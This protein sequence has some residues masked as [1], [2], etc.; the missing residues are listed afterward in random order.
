M[1]DYKIKIGLAPI[2]RDVTPRPGIFNWEKAE[3]RAEKYVKYITEHFTED[4]VEF[5]NVDGVNE[6]NIIYTEADAEVIADR[7]ISEKVDA[8]FVINCN[9]GNE[10]AAA[11]LCKRVGKPALLWAPLDDVFEADGM[12]YTDSQCGLFG[13]SKQFVRRKI[14]FS[15]IPNCRV[16]EKAF[17]DGLN[18]FISVAC[19]VK[20]FK[21][22]R[23]GQVGLRPKPFCSVIYNE[24]ELMENFDIRVIPINMA[25]IA[26][27]YNRILAERMD[28]CKKGS[29]IL[30]KNYE[31]D[32]LSADKLEKIY[33][34]VLMYIDLFKEHDLDVIASECWTSMQLAFG[35]MPCAALSILADMGY[36]VGCETDVHASITQALLKCASRGKG[37]PFLGEFTVRHPE[38]I[39]TELLWHCG[40]FAYSL[41]KPESPSKLVNMR[42]WFNVKNGSYTAARLDQE[43][44]K[45]SIIVGNC[46]SADGPYTFGTYLWA[47]FENLPLWEKR[48][49]EGPYIHHISEIE[50]DYVAE[51]EEFCKFIGDITPEIIK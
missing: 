2:R 16:E 46:N 23:V 15:Y 28:E 38:D 24:S 33:A 25:V 49:I 19:M 47:K 29:E 11:E 42:P 41:K 20:N 35:A 43:Y 10:E 36:I 37:T 30:K 40:P 39:N 18:K 34:F 17:A 48:M 7:F 51:F 45:Y 22:L 21:G 4:G 13:M 14:P 31:I 12:R 32:D 1:L 5:V 26:D 3:E 44:G 27:K 8:V 50:G 6:R 9:F